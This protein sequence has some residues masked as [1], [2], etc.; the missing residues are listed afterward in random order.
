MTG[1]GTIKRYTLA[2]IDAMIARGEDQTRPDA[3]EGP[4]MG[5]KFWKN[6]IVV[7]PDRKSSVHLRIDAD[8][9]HWFKRQGKGHL[10]RMNAV[11]RAYYEA[12]RSELRGTR[13]KTAT[14]RPGSKKISRGKPK[15]AV[16]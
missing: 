2:E 3:P 15:L 10:T 14:R 11:L 12:H 7:G 1:K 9:L 6:A 4:P 5:E 8:V 16:D 13:P